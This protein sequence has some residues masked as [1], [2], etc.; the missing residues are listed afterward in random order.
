MN[1]RTFVL[2][3]CLIAS[4]FANSTAIAQMKGH[5]NSPSRIGM[6][7]A[8]TPPS[9]PRLPMHRAPLMN[10]TLGPSFNRFN[11]GDFDRSDRSRRYHRFNKIIFIGN[12]GFPWGPWW[13][14][15]WGHYPQPPYEYSEYYPSY[16]SGSEYGHGN[17]GYAYG[18]GYPSALYYG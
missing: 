7:G 17:S 16:Y 6:R 4:V 1:R 12:F 13:G 3:G 9:I 15:N 18:Y 5:A 2:L 10:S 8:F 11:Y 14:W